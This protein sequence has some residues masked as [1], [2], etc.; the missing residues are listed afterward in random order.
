MS[1]K[2]NS[3]S[4]DEVPQWFQNFL[5]NIGGQFPQVNRG[6]TPNANT[7]VAVAYTNSSDDSCSNTRS[8]PVTSTCTTKGKQAVI[9]NCSVFDAM[10]GQQQFN[11]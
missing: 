2:N 9:D 5:K 1:Y 3:S 8:P 11:R 6:N 10:D 4:Q 7:P